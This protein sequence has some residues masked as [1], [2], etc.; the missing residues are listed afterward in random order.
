MRLIHAKKTRKPAVYHQIGRVRGFKG[1]EFIF[2]SKVFLFTFIIRDFHK[3][4][5][6]LALQSKVDFRYTIDTQMKKLIPSFILKAIRPVYHGLV[7]WWGSVWFGHPSEKLIV[8]GVTGTNGKSTTVNLIAKIL[9]EAGHKVGYTSTVTVNI[10][11]QEHLN[12][13]K[14]TMPSG[15]LLQ[16]W[17]KKMLDSKCQY[18]VLEISSEGLAQHRHVGIHFDAAVFTNLTPEHLEAHGGFENYKKAKGKLFEALGAR[19]KLIE[20]KRVP[21]TIVTNADDEHSEYFKSFKADTYISYGVKNNADYKVG[22][23]KTSLR[24]V[25]FNLNSLAFSL[26][27]KGKFDVYNAACAIASVS[28]FGVRLQT[29]KTALEKILGVPGRVE[30]IQEKPFLVVVDYAYEPE[31]MRQLYATVQT[32][33]HRRMIQV[34]G[35]TGGGRD[36]ARIPVLGKMA[37][38]TADIV[39]VTTDDPY[40]DDPKALIHAMADAAVEQGKIIGQTLFRN[41]DRRGG[42]VKALSLAQPEDLVLITGKGADQKMALAHGKYIDWDDRKVAREELGYK[43]LQDK[44]IHTQETL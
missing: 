7:A 5:K 20:G 41:P 16:K 27:L 10:D 42:I 17:L 30:V 3:I 39:V 23:F 1:I 18:A 14:M 4:S 44:K 22:G 8:I 33:P 24:G 43:E 37:A 34:L 26:H 9:Q 29:A 19:D 2:V 28:A 21:K 13:M 31:E 6:S 36:K 15:W 35:P 11:G 40:D 25:E 12:T 32:W 38:Q